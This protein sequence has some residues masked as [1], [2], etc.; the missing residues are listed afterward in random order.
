MTHAILLAAGAGARM[1]A[2]KALLDLGGCSAAARCAQALLDG[3]C[4]GLLVVLSAA[5]EAARATLPAA[6]R[7]VHNPHPASGQTGSLKLALAAV[8][9]GQDFLLHTV[10]HPLADADDVRALR[11]ALARAAPP[12]RIVLPQVGGRR[13]HPAACHAGLAAEFLAL[14]DDEPAHLV[15]RRDPARVLLLP[16]ANEWLVRDLDTPADLA[17]ARRAL[18]AR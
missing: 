11:E 12:V 17:A 10:D 7:A 1:G 13:G 15:M 14:G 8:P 18:A 6:A 16:R 5:S 3:G 4:D 9:P 2:P